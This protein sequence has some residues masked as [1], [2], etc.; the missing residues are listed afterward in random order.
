MDSKTKALLWQAYREYEDEGDAI[1]P[2]VL[3]APVEELEECPHQEST[4]PGTWVDS[5]VGL[6]DDGSDPYDDDY[7]QDRSDEYLNDYDARY[8]VVAKEIPPG[9]VKCSACDGS[10]LDYVADDISYGDPVFCGVCEGEGH[11]AQD[12]LVACDR[13]LDG[14]H[15]VWDEGRSY[16]RYCYN[17]DGTGRMLPEF[18]FPDLSAI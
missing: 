9:A 18:A 8:Q 16:R 6:F 10:G 7:W 15:T 13:C 5:Y 14:W 4:T 11:V 12:L 2:S 1:R 17:C 3:A